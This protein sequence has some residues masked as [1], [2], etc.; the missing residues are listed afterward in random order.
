VS[1]PVASIWFLPPYLFS[2][3]HNPL[4][5]SFVISVSFPLILFNYLSLD[6][7]AIIIFT[8]VFFEKRKKEEKREKGRVVCLLVFLPA[9]VL[10]T[11]FV[12]SVLLGRSRWSWEFR[13]LCSIEIFYSRSSVWVNSVRLQLQA[14]DY[15]RWWGK[16]YSRYA[17]VTGAMFF[18]LCFYLLLIDDSFNS[19]SL[20]LSLYFLLKFFF[21]NHLVSFYFLNEKE[22]K[23]KTKFIPMFFKLLLRFFLVCSFLFRPKLS[24]MNDSS[25]LID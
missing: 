12:G 25:F 4:F 14:F 9:S 6:Y 13:L 8:F 24:S 23:T 3:A 5:K 17:N 11:F 2:A 16:R 7:V 20:F 1:H 15:K 18:V 22:K 21:K 10:F 19:L